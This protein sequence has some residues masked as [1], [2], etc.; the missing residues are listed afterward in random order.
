MYKW[1]T[2]LAGENVELDLSVEQIIK[3]KLAQVEQARLLKEFIKPVE[4][5]QGASAAGV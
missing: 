3:D 2:Q 5:E 4:D 1:H